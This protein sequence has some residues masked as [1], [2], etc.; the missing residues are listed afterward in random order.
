[1]LARSKRQP[2]VRMSSWIE[3]PTDSKFVETKI[4]LVEIAKLKDRGLIAEDVVIDFIFKNIHPLKDRV[5]PIYVC[6]IVRDPSQVT[7][8]R[9]LE[10]LILSQVKMMLRGA[11]VNVGAPRSY[12]VWNLLELGSSDH[13]ISCPTLTELLCD[14]C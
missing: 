8:K 12:Y 13:L 9:I 14:L 7:D 11:I 1:L 2:D 6:T 4:L 10:E 3:A 5:H